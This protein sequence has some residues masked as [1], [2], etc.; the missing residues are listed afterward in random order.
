VGITLMPVLAVK[1]PIAK[2]N[3]LVIRPFS[4]SAPFRTIALVWR[5]SSALGPFLRELAESFRK[6]PKG[7]LVP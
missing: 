4:G 5:S 6:L 7:L 1:P 2:T 3:N